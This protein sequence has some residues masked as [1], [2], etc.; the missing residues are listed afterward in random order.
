SKNLIL[1]NLRSEHLIKDVPTNSIIPL[2]STVK[3]TILSR[4]S[5]FFLHLYAEEYKQDTKSKAFRQAASEK[6]FRKKCFYLT[7]SQKIIQAD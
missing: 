1:K 7:K 2:F 3:R 6:K 4:S 5:C